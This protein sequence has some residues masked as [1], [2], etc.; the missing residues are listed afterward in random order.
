MY[1]YAEEELKKDITETSEKYLSEWKQ[2]IYQKIGRIDFAFWYGNEIQ[3][4]MKEKME[5]DEKKENSEI[6]KFPIIEEELMTVIKNMKNGKAAGIDGVSAELM[7]HITK[8][9]E[10][11]KYMLKCINN[12]L[13]EKI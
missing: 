12:V 11:R 10:I 1:I 4:G 8:N 7:K 6:M 5:E 3:K 2:K 13:K 9:E